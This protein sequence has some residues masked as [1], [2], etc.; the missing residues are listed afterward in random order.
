MSVYV[1]KPLTDTS[2]ILLKDGAQYALITSKN[3]ELISFGSKL[4][5][6]KFSDI[7]DLN[8]F[9]GSKVTIEKTEDDS[10]EEIGNVN[11]YPVKHATA[12]ALE[13]QELPVYKRTAN[14]NT[15]YCAGYYGV[16]FPNGWVQSYCPK[17]LTLQENEFIGPFTTK[18]EMQNA[19]SQKK[20]AIDL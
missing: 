1:L 10:V 20:K 15:L 3:N 5:R 11:S 7:E 17:I 14:S 9:L 12:I 18:L 6:N 8:K 13:D 2:W 19:I 4:E 16:K